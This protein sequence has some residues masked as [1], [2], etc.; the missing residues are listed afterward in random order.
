M[1]YCCDAGKKKSKV[2]TCIRRTDKK[3]F[4]L[5]RRFSYKSCK[6]PKGF[7]MRASCAPFRGCDKKSRKSD[8]KTKQKRSKRSKKKS[9]KK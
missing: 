2:K 5:P 3:V 7:T 1:V 9:K 4:D 6:N 8:K